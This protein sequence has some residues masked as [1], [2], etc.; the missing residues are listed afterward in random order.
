MA[1]ATLRIIPIVTKG[2]VCHVCLTSFSV[3]AEK[4]QHKASKPELQA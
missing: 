2:V 3:R 1:H 4:D